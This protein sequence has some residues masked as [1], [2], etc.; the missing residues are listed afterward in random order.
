MPFERNIH[1][2]L[3]QFS[4]ARVCCQKRNSVLADVLKCSM[5]LLGA[6][7]ALSMELAGS[8]LRQAAVS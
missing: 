6:R 1:T 5:L 7:V 8:A 4:K 2:L 3:Q